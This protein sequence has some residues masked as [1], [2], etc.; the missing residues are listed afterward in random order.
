MP[1]YELPR[2][3]GG[4]RAYCPGERLILTAEEKADVEAWLPDEN[5][6]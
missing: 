4:R 2:P 3:S 6:T 1:I 5:A